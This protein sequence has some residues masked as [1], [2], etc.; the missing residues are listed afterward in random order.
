VDKAFKEFAASVIKIK[1]FY[2][3]VDRI[4]RQ[5]LFLRDQRVPLDALHE[6]RVLCRSSGIALRHVI[7][8][9]DIQHT[10]VKC[11]RVHDS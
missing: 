5:R 9:N 7:Q 4:Y 6:Q 8:Y 10:G 3:N 11:D 1:K 2:D